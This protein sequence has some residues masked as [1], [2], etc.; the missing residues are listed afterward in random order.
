MILL[1]SNNAT[2]T[3][4]AGIGTGATS[5]TLS[6]GTGALFPAPGANEYFP[7]TLNDA[8]TGLVYEITWCTART[9][10]VC[11]VLR[12]QEGTS[13][14]SWLI[15][16]FAY[17]ANTAIS[18]YTGRAF[19]STNAPTLPFTIPAVHLGVTQVCSATG[20]LTLPN[21]TGIPD[22]FMCA[23]VCTTSS[24]T[25]TVNTN[26]ATVAFPSGNVTTTFPVTGLGGSITLQWSA[27]ESVWYVIASTAAP[28]VLGI[29]TNTT[30]ALSQNGALVEMQSGPSFTTALPN[31][32]TVTGAFF[33]FYNASNVNQVLFS[34][35]GGFAGPNGQG[36]ATS[37][38]M[39]PN[40]SLRAQSDGSNWIMTNL[41]PGGTSVLTPLTGSGTY[42]VTKQTL[43]YRMWGAG[44]GG[45]A[46]ST[47][48]GGFGGG[49]A[50]YSEGYLTGLLI[51]STLSYAVGAGGAAGVAVGAGGNGGATT[52][53]S[54]TAGGGSGGA[55][56][57]SGTGGSGGTAT[58]G[59]FNA[60]GEAG[61]NAYGTGTGAVSGP[62]GAAWGQTGGPVAVAA[63]G[64]TP[65]APGGGG[66][67]GSPNGGVA[68]NGGA[69]ANGLILI[70][71]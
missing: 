71:Q 31:A 17:N 32:T 3:L 44:G 1:S 50:G 20:T 43:K 58:G 2:T 30:L 63:A 22:G 24:A 26:G 68:Q 19:S 53:G 45:G 8:A 18:I 12:A 9:G 37:M 42:V 16:D 39:A 47:T 51:G 38:T 62:G 28:I 11:T 56:A 66:S 46:S 6:S 23:V 57:A 52:L 40:T 14:H 48:Q 35:G 25:I 10:D 5:I 36:G 59:Q 67:G 41:S 7:L 49:G 55:G 65:Q 13:A 4:A 34:F 54:I 70:E 60:T 29:S 69:G 61:G 27:L 64:N 15:G 21:T 33:N